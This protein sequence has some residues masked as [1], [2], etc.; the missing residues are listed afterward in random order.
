MSINIQNQNISEF[1]RFCLVGVVCTGLDASIFYV[2]CMFAPYQV[3]LVSGYVLS[4][5]LNYF[6]TI[7][8]TFKSKPTAKNGIGIVAAHL[9]NLF[10][11]RMGLMYIFVELLNANDRIAYIPTLLISVVTNF[12][13][14]KFVIE[15]LK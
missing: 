15:K 3:A 11:V 12:V 2:V 4:L 7:Y 13:V 8:W 10:V 14:I 6:L 1:I 9:F 5:I